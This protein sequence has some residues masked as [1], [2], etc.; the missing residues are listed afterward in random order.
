[1]TN[2]NK[3]KLVT[4]DDVKQLAFD[5]GDVM[6][7]VQLV[8]DLIDF[9]PSVKDPKVHANPLYYYGTTQKA[10]ENVFAINRGIDKSLDDIASKLYDMVDELEELKK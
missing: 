5:V 1:M 8:S 2:K 4:A 7:I 3:F 10:L 6:D 9:M